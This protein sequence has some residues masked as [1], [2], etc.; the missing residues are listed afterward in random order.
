MKIPFIGGAYSGLSKHANAQD[1]LN[2]YLEN[3]QHGGRP[4]LIGTPGLLRK[5]WIPNLKPTYGD[6]FDNLV[7]FGDGN[8]SLTGITFEINS[9]SIPDNTTTGEVTLTGT[10]GNLSAVSDTIGTGWFGD[11]EVAVYRYVAGV[12]T[13]QDKFTV[14][15]DADDGDWAFEQTVTLADEGIFY[16]RLEW[17]ASQAFIVNKIVPGSLQIE[18]KGDPDE[19]NPLYNESLPLLQE[20]NGYSNARVISSPDGATVYRVQYSYNNTTTYDIDTSYNSYIIDYTCADT[21]SSYDTDPDPVGSWDFYPIMILGQVIGESQLLR[22]VKIRSGG[23]AVSS[24]EIAANIRYQVTGSATSVVYNNETYTPGGHDTFVGVAGVATFEKT[25]DGDVI[26]LT[27]KEYYEKYADTVSAEGMAKALIAACTYGSETY[28]DLWV[29]GI[30][31]LQYPLSYTG[32]HSGNTGNFAELY[33]FYGRLTVSG[34]EKVEAV[35]PCFRLAPAM[36]VAIAL[37]FYAK[38][39]TTY[40]TDA[41]NRL[42]LLLIH[43]IDNYFVSTDGMQQYLFRNGKGVYE[44]HGLSKTFHKDVKR[45]D[46]PLE[47]NMLAW[48]ALGLAVELGLSV[49]DGIGKDYLYLQGKLETALKGLIEDNG[50]WHPNKKRPMN[51]GAS[52]VLQSSTVDNT[53]RLRGNLSN[54]LTEGT[55][56]SLRGGALT[57]EFTV[58]SAVNETTEITDTVST[59]TLYKATGQFTYGGITYYATETEPIV[60]FAG[61]ETTITITDGTIVPCETIVT[62]S[63]TVGTAISYSADEDRYALFLDKTVSADAYSI[64]TVAYVNM[65]ESVKAGYVFDFL[66]KMYVTDTITINDIHV[67]IPGFEPY[68]QDVEE[69]VLDDTETYPLTTVTTNGRSYTIIESKNVEPW[70]TYGNYWETGHLSVS[71]TCSAILAAAARK[72]FDLVQIYFDALYPIRDELTDGYPH[73]DWENQESDYSLTPHM[74]IEYSDG[75]YYVCDFAGLEDTAMAII[76][77]KTNGLF[78]IQDMGIT[79]T[80]RSYSNEIRGMTR[81]GDYLYVVVG[82][83][84]VRMNSEWSVECICTFPLYYDS[85]PVCMVTNGNAIF[86]TE[87]IAGVGYHY[88]PT[89]ETWTRV[90]EVDHG[91]IGGGTLTTQD[92]Y[93]IS[94]VPETQLV[95]FSENGLAW[96]SLDTCSAEYKPDSAVRVYS[97]FGQL[98]IFG[99]ESSEIFYNSGVANNVFQRVS[100]GTLDVGCIAPHSVVALDNGFFWLSNDK[101]VRRASSPN[102]QVVSPPQIVA[103]FEQYETVSDAVGIG[104]ILGGKAFYELTFPSANATWLYE[105]STGNWVRLSSYQEYND[106]DGRH[107]TN[108]IC[109]FDN[110]IIAGDYENGSIYQLDHD[111]Y[112]DNGHRI[113]RSRTAPVIMDDQ[114][115][116]LISIHSLEI[117]FE[118]GVGLEYGQGEEPKA[119]LRMSDDGGYT[120]GNEH[121]KSI[122]RIGQ[123]KNRVRWT[124]LGV[125]RNK[126]FKVTISDPVRVVMIDA[127]INFSTGGV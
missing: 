64:A 104:Y 89:T 105:I 50:L 86:I 79:L 15:E 100:G 95:Q 19:T 118:P 65:G 126:V 31:K 114:N 107:R 98:W 106:M 18:L 3:D 22:T 10:V 53:I 96:D 21:L 61:T 120:F 43:W 38:K 14:S 88:N 6:D 58:S 87:G 123:Y 62:V 44:N 1:C 74:G 113:I 56:L 110:I 83:I 4:S 85:G 103:I 48:I 66:K 23:E 84:V 80:G 93:F 81:L 16:A 70:T 8:S 41:E 91:F 101:T 121:W 68:L 20:L 122:G 29:Q 69:T 27:S 77:Q 108:C 54:I 12:L 13:Y 7:S 45:N 35:Q 33:D 5:T 55:T 51:L 28:A 112:T 78:S 99:E 47:G 90:T 75:Y 63:E 37:G 52:Q 71:H 39:Y 125:A 25:G 59:G 124:R 94:N 73:T 46:S 2:L 115:H 36:W 30:L 32:I 97:E 111:T 24:G 40:K 92:G 117:Q 17:I 42:I 119:M 76:V 82:N 49:S 109:R 9:D 26:N 57:G 60:F 102:S 11:I 67:S 72:D 34:A 127:I 116:G